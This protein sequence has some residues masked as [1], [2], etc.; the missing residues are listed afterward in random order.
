MALEQLAKMARVVEDAWCTAWASLGALPA[1]P[2]TLVEQTP[3]SLRIYT[4]G[5]PEMLLNIVLRYSA[6][7]PVTAADV[8]RVIAPFRRY[9]LPFQWWVNPDAEPQGLSRQLHALGM[10]TWGGSATS[11][12]LELAGW[13]PA[14]PPV[15]SGVTLTRVT[16]PSEAQQALEVICD[17]FYVPTGPMA[18]WTTEN[19]ACWVYLASWNGRPM[20]ALATLP[21]DG[22]VGV[23][24][25]ATL[26]FARR[27]GLAGN[28]LILALREAREAGCTLAALTATPEAIRLYEQLGF[29]TCG[30]IEQWAPGTGL[31][32]ELTRGAGP[33]PIGS[34][35]E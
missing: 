27:R 9:R 8:E 1:T 5:V 25:V 28:L 4:P 29:R 15:A 12:V 20:A 21:R 18:R 24:H 17:V 32:N 23:F 6:P 14:Y 22:V 13:A 2:P 3:D 16:T 34:A 35:W 31:T 11:M 33:Y 10:R 7:G 26:P 30:A 19:P